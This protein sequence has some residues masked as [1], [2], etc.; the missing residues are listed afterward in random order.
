MS[1]IRNVI[2]NAVANNLDETVYYVED[3]YS[4]HINTVEQALLEREWAITDE[5]KSVALHRTDFSD[6]QIDE[7]FELVG[8]SVRPQPE[9]E[10]EVSAELPDEDIDPDAPVTRAEFAQLERN[11]SKAVEALQVLTGLLDRHLGP[12][13][14]NVESN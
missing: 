5:L 7:V 6:D 14:I 1:A 12:V 13:N 2:V 11:V 4:T 10:P 8:L 9:P 3:N